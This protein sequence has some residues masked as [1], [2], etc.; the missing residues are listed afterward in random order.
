MAILNLPKTNAIESCRSVLYTLLCYLRLQ[1][2]LTRV[3]IIIIITCVQNPRARVHIFHHKRKS[4]NNGIILCIYV[5]VITYRHRIEA[6][7]SSR[8]RRIFFELLFR[9]WT[10]IVSDI[11][12]SSPPSPPLHRIYTRKLRHARVSS[13]PGTWRSYNC[14][15]RDRLNINDK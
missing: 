6:K 5:N 4:A 2:C 11:A 15:L 10:I 1:C 9:R 12:G 8:K 14:D 13:A 7:V 3:G